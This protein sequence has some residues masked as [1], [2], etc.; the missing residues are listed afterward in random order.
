MAAP[1]RPATVLPFRRSWPARPSASSG[2]PSA[3]MQQ[4]TGASHRD[5]PPGGQARG[6]RG[7]RGLE[8][9]LRHG[10]ARW[11]VA[12]DYC[13]PIVVFGLLTALESYLPAGLYPYAYIV[14]IGLVS[15]SL[16]WL[17][18]PLADIVPSSRVVLPAVLVG[19]AVTLQWVLVDAAVPYPHLGTRSAFDPFTAIEG[20]P[21]RWAFLG[22]RLFGLVLV[23]PVME[24]L[25]WRSFLLR[26]LTRPEFRTL[27]PG[28]FSWTAFWLVA[29]LFALSHPEWLVALVT[30]AAFALLLRWTRSLFAVVVAHAVANAALGAY[31]LA[32]GAWQFW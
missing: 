14:K 23:V 26:Y 18:G 5:P 4:P 6:A 24:E 2:Q 11:G 15:A 30:A 25:F 27:L 31:V 28:E 20:T 21:L 29:A 10:R 19:L 16:V 3:V 32:T 9:V 22:V 7:G 1:G 12:F 17:R 13:L 8:T